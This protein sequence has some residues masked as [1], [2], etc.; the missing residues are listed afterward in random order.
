LVLAYSTLLHNFETDFLICSIRFS[1]FIVN[2]VDLCG[3]VT[4][5]TKT[6]AD[7]K[8]GSNRLRCI[9]ICIFFL[10][11]YIALMKHGCFNVQ[12]YTNC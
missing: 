5:L 11:H 4:H 10:L 1:D 7:S 12:H 9:W 8:V 3:N 6:E 2:E